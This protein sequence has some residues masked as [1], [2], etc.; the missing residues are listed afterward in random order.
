VILN[1]MNANHAAVLAAAYLNNQTA[2]T[3]HLRRI[4]DF[5]LTAL[6]ASC[7]RL[8]TMTNDELL[9]NPSPRPWAHKSTCV[10]AGQFTLKAHWSGTA[11]P[12]ELVAT[13]RLT[14]IAVNS[15]EPH[16]ARIEELEEALRLALKELDDHAGTNYLEFRN[17]LSTVLSK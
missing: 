6:M 9:A 10:E 7:E 14:T 11:D 1:T 13:M 15:Y 8:T 2:S 4:Q 16:L 3:Q 17:H 5:A 12:T